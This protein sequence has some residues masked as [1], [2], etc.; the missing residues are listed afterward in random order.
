MGG[1]RVQCY[2]PGMASLDICHITPEI[3]PFAKVG[4]L[5][6]VA[7]ALPPAVAALGHTVRVVFPLYGRIDADRHGFQPLLRDLTL[8]LGRHEY[9][10]DVLRAEGPHGVEYLAVRCDPLY[11][12]DALYTDEP[13]EH[14][15]FLLL[16]R[17]AL[18]ICQHLQWGPA[19][20]HCH[21]WQ[22]ALVPVYLRSRYAWDRLFENSRS[23]LT[24]HNLGYQGTFPSTI[25]EDVG[26]PGNE[27]H[28]DADDLAAGR[29]GFLKSGIQA[30][31]LLTTVS[32]TY[33]EEIQTEA[34][35]FGLDGL[36]RS[37]AADLVGILNGVDDEVW[38]PRTDPLIPFH[39][40]AK[41][42]WRKVKNTEALLTAVGLPYEKGVPVVGIV[43]RL[44]TQKGLDLVQRPLDE[45]FTAGA[46]RG[47][48]LGTGEPDLEAQFHALQ[49][50][51]PQNFC[52][53]RGF[54]EELAHLVEAGSNFFLMPSRYEPCGLNQMYSQLY[55][56][57]PLVRRTGGL[58]DSVKQ[59]D[60]ATSAGTGVLFDHATEDGVRWALRTAL[61]AYRDP[62]LWR[63]I[64]E[65]GMTRD[66]S[67]RR[68]A[69]EYV[70]VYN[71]LVD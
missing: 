29:V 49:R 12:R 32:P 67:W 5:A 37:R 6:D 51:H 28:L 53:Y 70:D 30:A 27:H 23:V 46:M 57:V 7:G 61:S 45:Q 55:G 8:D 41:S 10:V 14:L 39:Y 47:V 1:S 34:M 63:R 66:F 26:L 54:S 17:A 44:A 38:N 58:A 60:P 31:D 19:I 68:R 62:E 4:G 20:F 15:R 59:I 40:S 11:G 22:T 36:L 16:S 21:D 33:A 43:S 50:R 65:N 35:G 13:D 42:P 64:V 56:C 48:V 2:T 52:F 3:S 71:R 25:L 9:T 24:L 69:S 18:E